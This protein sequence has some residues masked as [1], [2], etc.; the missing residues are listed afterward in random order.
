MVSTTYMVMTGG[1]FSI[2]LPTFV[3]F[4]SPLDQKT[5]A[6]HLGTWW[7]HHGTQ[8]IAKNSLESTDLPEPK[9]EKNDVVLLTPI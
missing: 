5:G 1:W 9:K 8:A 2:A 6:Y 3:D 7:G 4:G